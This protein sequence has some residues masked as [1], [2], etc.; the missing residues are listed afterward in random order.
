MTQFHFPKGFL[1]GAA[2]A[3]YQIEGA[4][5][6]D[7]K[8]ESIW[9]RF[10]HTPG[11][12]RD[13]STGDV[14][15]DHYHRWRDDVALIKELGL[16]AYRFSISWP[17]ILPQGHGQANQRGLDFYR[18]LV[19]ELLASE[20][21]PFVTL[22][23]WDLPQALEDQGG[24]PARSTVEAFADFADVVSRALGDRVKHWITLNE[25]CCFCSHGY[26]LGIHAPGREDRRAALAA[27][28]H[29][30]LAHG[31]AVDLIRRN[32]PGAEVGI[33]LDVNPAVPAS[34]SAADADAARHHDGYFNRWFLDPLY[35][36]GY[37]SDMVDDYAADGALPP[38]GLSFVWPGDMRAIAA[39]TDLL[40]INYYSRTITR[41]SRIPEE[42]NLPRVAAAGA[43][44][45][46]GWEIYPDG[47]YEMLARLHFTYHPDKLYVTENGASYIDRLDGD[48]EVHDMQRLSYLRE[49]FLAAQRAIAAGVPLAGYFVW[50]LFDNFEW[51]EGLSDRFGIVYVDFAT[52][53][54]IPKDSA[55]WLKQVIATNRVV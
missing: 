3:A 53:R 44:T 46:R 41:S 6:E 43:R 36:R 31:L 7:G 35:G 23:H 17:R 24:W 11:R 10:A 18:R 55:L 48:G 47:L 40:G 34:P 26:Q 32:S 22:Y 16:R 4:W 27:T 42:H 25:P 12:I 20:I 51:A 29:A 21:V 50:S 30:L 8:G 1:W 49:H 37:P 45:D 54:R 52:Q 38:S 14:A 9:D 33:T 39:P 19:D 2:T 13:G 5:N 28:H 15:C